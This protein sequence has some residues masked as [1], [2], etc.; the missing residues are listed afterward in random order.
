[1]GAIGYLLLGAVLLLL[2]GDSLV[3]AAAGLGQRLGLSAFGASLLMGAVAGPL[4]L[5]VVPGY[6]FHVGAVELA[7]GAAVGSNVVLLGLGLGAA[8]LMA[9]LEV[10]RRGVAAELVFL[11]VATGAVMFTG[12]DGTVS[13]AEGAMLLLAYVLFL[14]FVFTVGRRE[15]EPVR[16]ALAEVATTGTSAAQNVVRLAIAAVV[17]V[18]GAKFLVTGASAIAPAWRLTPLMAGVLVVA[19]ATAVPAVVVGLLVARGARGNVL[20]G[21][22]LASGLANLLIAVGAMA[23][24]QPLPVPLSLVGFELPAAMV[25]AFVLTPVL[26]GDMRITRREGGL[27]LAMFTGW[28]GVEAVRVWG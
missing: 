13:R 23:L 9:P 2:G 26:G 22:A 21:L 11:L 12:V 27:L 17:L 3:R 1:M 6:A 14:A 7:L 8:A 15:A 5:L 18:F 10:S 24:L 4:S 20:V 19:P 16:A 25:L 28:L